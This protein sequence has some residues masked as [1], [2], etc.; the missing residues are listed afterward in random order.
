[1]RNSVETNTWPYSTSP[2]RIPLWTA[3]G[4][5]LCV[6][7]CSRS[8][9]SAVSQSGTRQALEAIVRD[10]AEQHRLPGLAAGVWRRGEV[11]LRMGVGHQNGPGSPPIDGETVFH[12]ASVTKPFVATAVMQLVDEGKMCLDCPLRRYLPYFSMQGPGADQITIRQLLTHTAGMGD[13]SDFGWTTP[14]YDDGAVERYVR[15]LA[16]L[17][18]DFAPGSGWR[19]SNRGFDVLADAIAKADGQ[20]F[21]A[22]IQ[23]RILMPLG[24]RRS[25][26]LMSDIDSARMARG[27]RRNGSAVGYYPYNRRHAGSSTL[28]STLDDMLRWAAANLGRG[29]LHQRRILPAAAFDELWRPYRDI[30]ATIAEQTRRAGYV[31]PYD[32]MAIGLSWFLPVQDGRELVYHSGSDPGFASNILLSPSEQIG[33]V[34]LMNASGAD[35]RALSRALLD[36][37]T[38]VP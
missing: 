5:L 22:V 2:R 34:V 37:A 29:A 25:T 30:R 1:M 35:P 10:F 24:M 16:T 14:E 4:A 8:S 15:S 13:T 12:L 6:A 11:I 26:L 31:F 18:V 38:E 33:V 17:R 28:H 7:A 19:Y 9:Q 20:P 36:A 3:I 32:S 23:R 21:E 27:H